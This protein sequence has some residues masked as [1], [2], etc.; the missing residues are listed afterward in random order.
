MYT[1]FFIYVIIVQATVL[2][3]LLLL[4]PERSS[5]SLDGQRSPKEKSLKISELNLS[6]DR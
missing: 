5:K 4:S 1:L 6:N 2:L 3:S